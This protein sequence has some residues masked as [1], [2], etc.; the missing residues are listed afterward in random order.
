MKDPKDPSFPGK[1]VWCKGNFSSYL[2]P[3]LEFKFPVKIIIMRPKSHKLKFQFQLIII[4]TLPE[5]NLAPKKFLFQEVI[6]RCHVSFREGIIHSFLCASVLA[7][8]RV[9][10]PWLF[11]PL[12]TLVWN[13]SI[14][15]FTVSRYCNLLVLCLGISRHSLWKTNGNEMRQNIHNYWGNWE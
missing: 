4:Y 14:A 5:T 8:T 11:S 15:S 9:G 12:K 6:F 1:T 7:A 13:S 3:K 10:F 2:V